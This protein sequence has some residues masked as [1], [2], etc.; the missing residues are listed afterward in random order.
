MRK[1]VI[2]I[3]S[4]V[5]A[6]PGEREC[7]MM[8]LT[9]V[10]SVRRAG[11]VPVIVPPQSE[12]AG[13]VVDSLD[14]LLL[15]GGEDCDPAAYGEERHS[16]V[17]P[18]DPRRQGN[19]L[20]LARAAREK[21]I[22][23]L[24]ICLGMQVMNVAAGGSLIQDIDSQ[25]GTEIRHASRPEARARHFVTVD[26][27]SS[28]GRIV[29]QNEIDVNSSHHQAVRNVGRGLV[30]TAKA[31][32][33]IVEGLEDPQ[34]PFYVGVQWHPEDMAGEGSAEAIF[35]AFIGAAAKRREHVATEA[36]SSVSTTSE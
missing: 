29:G 15:A 6:P 4:D 32:D 20:A 18:M 9:Y 19:D 36:S 26:A 34:H 21:N 30:V 13:D 7:A 11:G 1:P 8:F 27:S 25:H 23:T 2:G 33:G 31:P 35:A 22:P 16:T 17:A 3:G 14:G 24:G 5:L 12:N 28:L 10:E